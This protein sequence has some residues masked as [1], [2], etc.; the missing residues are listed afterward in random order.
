HVS[1]PGYDKYLLV[2]GT[3][4]SHI[5]VATI[6]PGSGGLTEVAS[7]STVGGSSK[8]IEIGIVNNTI[9]LFSAEGSGGLR[10]Y[11]FQPP[12]TILNVP[13]FIAGNFNRLAVRGPAPYPVLFAHRK[14]S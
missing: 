13:T 4:D 6:D 1:I 2:G 7:A 9:I 3:T 11:E 10:V 5:H 8:Q 14:V 12:G